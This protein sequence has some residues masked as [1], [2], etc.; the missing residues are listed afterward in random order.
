Y[1]IVFLCQP[2]GAAVVEASH[3]H[4]VHETHWFAE[5]ELP[6]AIDPG[7]VSRIPIAFQIYR[8]ER[9]PFFD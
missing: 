4:E 9:T 2:T 1:Q 5:A 8:G 3:A 7:H 6:T